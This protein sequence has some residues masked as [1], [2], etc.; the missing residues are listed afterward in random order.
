M[1]STHPIKCNNYILRKNQQ[2]KYRHL[3]YSLRQFRHNKI[4]IFLPLKDS[5]S[6]NKEQAIIN[7]KLYYFG[8]DLFVL[9]LTSGQ[10]NFIS[11]VKQKILPVQP[12]IQCEAG[13]AKTKLFVL[14]GLKMAAE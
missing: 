10:F 3:N 12:L 1:I 14:L 11:Q 7:W 9:Y 6:R 4:Q 13:Q 2:I 5:S 8:K